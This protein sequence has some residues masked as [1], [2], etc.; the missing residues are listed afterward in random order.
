MDNKIQTGL[1]AKDK[2]KFGKIEFNNWLIE[3]EF[4]EEKEKGYERIHRAP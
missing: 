1:F 4:E 2:L 3:G